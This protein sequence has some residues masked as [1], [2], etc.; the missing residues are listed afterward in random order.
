MPLDFVYRCRRSVWQQCRAQA[1]P[2][3][4]KIVTVGQ[5]VSTAVSDRHDSIA[6]IRE[7]RYA[8]P[9]WAGYHRGP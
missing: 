1:G 2:R 6:I 4:S 5:G 7:P 8:S 3:G 9:N